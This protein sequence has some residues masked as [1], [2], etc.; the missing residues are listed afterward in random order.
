M[1]A[2]R[3]RKLYLGPRL[4]ML[5]RELGLTQTRM[6]D[7]LGVSPSYLNHLERNQRPL[8]APMLLRLADTYDLDVRGFVAGAGEAAASDLGEILADD[9]VRELAIGRQ[10]VLEVAENYPNVA[11]AVKRLYRA[12]V[13]L[14]Q[15]PGRIESAAG[16][17]DAPAASPIGWLRDWIEGEQSHFP[18]IDTAA[19]ALSAALGEGPEALRAAMVARLGETP[20]IAVRVVGQDV[21]GD[22]LHHYDLHRRRLMLSERL[23]ASGRLFA[24]AAQLARTALSDP[25]AEVLATAAPP[26]AETRALT[27][28]T[29]VN[30]AAAALVM[31]YGRV[32]AAAE[33]SGY[34]LDLIAARFGVSV[35]QAAQRLTTLGRSSAPGLTLFFLNLDVAGN[36]AKRLALASAPFARFGGGC[37]R[38]RAHLAMQRSGETIVDLVELPDGQRYLTWA[39]AITGS[40][41][42]RPSLLV[43]GCDAA[44]GG[45]TVYGRQPLEPTP[46]GPAC[47]LCER[48]DCRERS[49]PPITRALDIN[50]N[51]RPLA[52]YPFRAI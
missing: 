18:G 24:I 4:R 44:E 15:L 17:A 30:Y 31:P 6:A 25:I 14:R 16:G 8:T 23:S 27:A 1:A 32:H 33:A 41:T 36:V 46:I 29:L 47:H 49:L 5:R 51:R 19:E 28:Q 52:P 20:G 43:M 48:P 12:L 21:L 50:P 37:P 34:D 9:L 22:A 13:D 3:D 11:E 2:T 42:R 35:A 38:W 10:E 26:D 40:R 7:E 45:R 39:R